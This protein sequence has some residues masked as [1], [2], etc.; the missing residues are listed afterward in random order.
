M[1]TLYIL[2]GP[3]GTGKTT[4]YYTAVEFDFISRELSFVNVD[5][6][7]QQLGGYSE[8]NYARAPDIYR[9]ILKGHIERNEDFMI[10]SNL[11]E[12]KN[13]DWISAIKKQGYEIVLYYLS[14]D[15]VEINIARVRRRVQEGG[16][17]IP[18]AIIRHRYSVS[19]SYLKTK[20]FMFKQVFLI[21]NTTDI[22]KICAILVDGIIIERRQVC[23]AWVGSSLSMI[24]KIQNKQQR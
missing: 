24:E 10:E 13:Y 17:D 18:E 22:F 12:S 4:F 11:A 16:H 5:L 9:E 19:H 21:D 20:F 7:A 3:N 2:A 1:P 15:D 6:I 8:E 23:P 14:T